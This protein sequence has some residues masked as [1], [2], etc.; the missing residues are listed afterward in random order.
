MHTVYSAHSC[1]VQL[2]SDS[3]LMLPLSNK[4][5]ADADEAHSALHFCLDLQGYSPWCVV[6]V[7]A[8]SRQLRVLMSCTWSIAHALAERFSWIRCSTVCCVRQLTWA[9][10][11]QLIVLGSSYHLTSEHYSNRFLK[12]LAMCRMIAAKTTM[13]SIC[14]CIVVQFYTFTTGR[15]LPDQAMPHPTACSPAVAVLS[16]LR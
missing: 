1:L 2:L 4:H 13:S 7:A 16:P 9:C 5:T 8:S 15:L 12:R 11:M 3:T 10:C 6:L 14:T